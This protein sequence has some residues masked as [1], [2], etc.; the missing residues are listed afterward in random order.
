M[1]EHTYLSSCHEEVKIV[2]P[3]WTYMYMYVCVHVHMYNYV[4]HMCIQCTCTWSQQ[5]VI[6]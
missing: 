3:T 4:V 5:S 1:H 6:D 2:P